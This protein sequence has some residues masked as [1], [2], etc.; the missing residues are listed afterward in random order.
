MT[1]GRRLWVVAGAAVL[2]RLALAVATGGN[3]DIEHMVFIADLLRTAALDADAGQRPDDLAWP[4]P[5]GYFPLLVLI[6]GAQRLAGVPFALGA[7]LV[8]IAANVALVLVVD[9][10]LRRAAAARSTRQV[11]AGVLLLSPLLVLETGWHAQVDVVAVLLATSA[12][13]LWSSLPTGR[14]AWVAGALIGGAACVKIVP[15]VVLIALLATARTR[16]E[17]AILVGSAAAVVLVAVAPWLLRDADAMVSRFGYRGLPGIGGLSVLV[18]PGL[19]E[20]WLNG[21]DVPLSGAQR[22][23]QEHASLVNLATLLPAAGLVLWRRPAPA[24]GACLLLLGV[25]AGAANLALHYL[26]WI[27]PMLLLAGWNRAAA[28]L[29]GA[30]LPLVVLVYW[31]AIDGTLTTPASP[32]PDW[33]TRAVYVPVA[34][35]LLLAALASLAWLAARLARGRDVD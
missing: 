3:G 31:P 32:W 5:P 27:T 11:A 21:A 8:A 13:V 33:L 20:L 7:R 4:Y 15:G 14:R 23:L 29:H 34:V 2:L 9:A 22:R 18:Q 30:L 10:G 26:V 17:A 25:Y 19:A 12:V 35:A 28:L 6:D 16:R 24:A 1:L